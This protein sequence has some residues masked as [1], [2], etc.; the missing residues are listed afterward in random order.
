MRSDG[1]VDQAEGLRR[2]LVGSQTQVVTVVAGRAGMGRT[3]ATVNLAAALVRSGKDVLVLDENH[4]PDNLLD[5]LALSEHYDVVLLG[6]GLGEKKEFVLKLLRDI[7]KPFVIDADALK[8]IA[9]DVPTN[10]I[11]TPNPKEFRILYENTVKKEFDELDMEPNIRAMQEKLGNNIMLLKGPED[12]IFTKH[13]RHT[14]KTGHNSMTRG[15]TGDILAGICAGFLAQSGNLFDSAK[16]AAYI[17][18]RLGEFM[19]KQKSYGYTAF[20]MVEELWR[21]IK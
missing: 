20:D 15:G 5:A 2:L 16:E 21:F 11:L 17:N 4:A 9:L 14:N 19:Y 13:R 6:P 10:S 7:K 18:G 3:S 1:G 8:V 12:I